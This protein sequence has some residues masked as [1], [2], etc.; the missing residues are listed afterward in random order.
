MN[1]TNTMSLIETGA[2]GSFRRHVG[3]VDST[4]KEWAERRQSRR[5]LAMMDARTLR[6]IGLSVSDRQYECAKPFWRE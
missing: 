5:T 1:T 4:L 6:D 3:R 2:R